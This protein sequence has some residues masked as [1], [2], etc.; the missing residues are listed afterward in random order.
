MIHAHKPNS[1]IFDTVNILNL[2]GE[3]IYTYK[4]IINSQKELN[5]RLKDTVLFN[6]KLVFNDI[7]TDSEYINVTLI[8]LPTKYLRI[9]DTSFNEIIK[10]NIDMIKS[11]IKYG[12]YHKY[13]TINNLLN[14]LKM[15]INDEY[16][17]LSQPELYIYCYI[18]T[19]YTLNKSF[20]DINLVNLLYDDDQKILDCD[21]KIIIINL[22]SPVIYGAIK[23][24]DNI[25][26]IK[27]YYL[28]SKC[29]MY[30]YKC[31]GPI[32][33]CYT[34]TNNFYEITY[35]FIINND[36]NNPIKYFKNIDQL[37]FINSFDKYNEFKSYF[38]NEIQKNQQFFLNI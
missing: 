22:S 7:I 27:N 18:N 11:P 29:A 30:K 21:Y 9:Y 37:F 4:Y 19:N 5:K 36:L 24:P 16:C 20:N 6:F 25:N 34:E 38:N 10:L 23:I 3:I 2:S 13:K 26:N 12:I 14:E 1:F 35:V 33:D 15:Y 31:I 32:T 8:Q 28:I 17:I